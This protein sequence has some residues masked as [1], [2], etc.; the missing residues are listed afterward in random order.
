M[1]VLFSFDFVIDLYVELDK[2]VNSALFNSFLI[3]PELI[4]NDKLT[5]LRSPVTEVVDA[6]AIVARKLVKEL[7][8]VTDNRSAEVSDVEGLGNVGR[9]IV[10][11]Y[12]L[13]D[14]IH[15]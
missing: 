3:T 2:L 1:L 11:D 8:G 10:E 7:K 4:C 12:F 9:G 5:E 14:A 13:T 15:R 6:E